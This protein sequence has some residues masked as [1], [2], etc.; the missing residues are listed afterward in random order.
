MKQKRNKQIKKRK[1]KGLMVKELMIKKI[2]I[3]KKKENKKMKTLI[4]KESKKTIIK[5][6]EK[7]KITKK[8]MLM[9]RLILIKNLKIKFQKL[10]KLCHKAT[11]SILIL[12]YNNKISR[13]KLNNKKLISFRFIIFFMQYKLSLLKNQSSK[14]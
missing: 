8:K 10:L 5:S 3:K 12:L 2:K 7:N 6:K 13:Y 11:T 4:Q 14:N 9:L 1:K